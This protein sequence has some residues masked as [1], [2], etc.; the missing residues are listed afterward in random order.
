ML[1]H[2]AEP[3]DSQEF[4]FEI[5]FDGTRTIAY[6]DAERKEV[7]FL[8]RRGIW[9]QE[10]Y[11]EM[12][13][14][15]KDV[16]ARKIILDGELV[17]FRHGK[18]DF[19]ALETRE[20]IA[21]GLRYSLLAKTMPAT[22]VVFDVLHIDGMDVV[23]KPLVERKRILEGVVKESL[24][25]VLSAYVVERGREFFEAVR[26]QG[27]EG[28][29]AKRLSSIYQAGKRSHDWLKIKALKSLDVVIGGFTKGR[30]WREP[31]FGALLVGIYHQGKL[32]YLG[33]VGTGLDEE[34]YAKLTQE[35][36]QLTTDQNPFEVF[37][38]EPRVV[39][40]AVFVE[41][42]LVAEV[43][44]MN[45]SEDLKMRAPSFKRLRKDKLPHECV[46]YES[47]LKHL[48]A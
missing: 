40:Q 44:F 3:F 17:V 24:R 35:L 7:R 21:N 1:A 42:Q 47:E 18:P 2:L 46:L 6:I 37:E 41:P 31:Y 34:G 28:V 39:E 45:L 26:K 12:R 5:K 9:F 16:R 32:R 23:E 25:I 14:L 27:L 30:G 10:R 43:K 33:R 48:Q 20:H 38:E 36:K 29:M 19:Y 22:L 8:N 4:L 13:E 15:W 11:P